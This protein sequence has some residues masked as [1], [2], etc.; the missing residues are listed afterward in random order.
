[1]RGAMCALSKSEHFLHSR[2]MDIFAFSASSFMSFLLTLIRVSLLVFLMPFYKEDY[3][4]IPVKAALCI[5]LTLSIWPQLSFPGELFPAHPIAIGVLVLAE[6]V[7]GLL[8]ALCVNFI[9]A[10]IH[11]G[12]EIMAFQMGFTMMSFADPTSGQNAS[13]TTHLLNAV[14]MMIFLSLDGHLILLRA[15]ADS[16]QYIPPGAVNITGTLTH[17]VLLLSAGIFSLAIRI[18][19]PVIA[20]L[21]LTELTLAIMGRAAPQMNLLTLGFPAKIS[22]GFFFIGILFTTL[23]LYMEDL[24]VGL[25]PM[26]DNI[27][28]SAR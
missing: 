16:F 14:C 23:T 4:P 22:V 13:V 5:V 28:R 2:A 8:L 11:T 15:M 1:M 9:F 21:F 20:A 10:A 12:S 26:F 27:L 7:L 17:D 3:F 19:A 25:G 6:V 24:I 18:A